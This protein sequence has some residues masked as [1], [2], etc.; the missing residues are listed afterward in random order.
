[1]PRD[2]LTDVT[3]RIRTGGRTAADGG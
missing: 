1:V 3:E 2:L